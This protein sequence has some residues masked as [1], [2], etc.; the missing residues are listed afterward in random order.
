M[1]AVLLLRRVQLHVYRFRR[2]INIEF[3]AERLIFRGDYLNLHGS[4]RNRWEVRNAMQV[5]MNLPM[6]G[7]AFAQLRDL[8][9]A[10][11]IENDIR[12]FDGLVELISY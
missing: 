10:E 1:R 5:G 12:V 7:F 9:R 6:D 3:I 11:K 8:M 4:L 2:R